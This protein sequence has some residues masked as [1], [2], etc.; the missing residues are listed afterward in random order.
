MR[1]REFLASGLA[2]SAA[3]LAGRAEAQAAP[4]SSSGEA[5]AGGSRQWLELRKYQLTQG[6]QGRLLSSYLSG[7][8]IPALNKMGIGPVGAFTLTYGPDTPATYLLLPSSSLETLV[9]VQEKLA[10]DPAFTEAAK[11]FWSVPAVSAPFV[12]VESQLLRAMAG[13]PAVTPPKEKPKNRCFQLRT[14]ESATDLDHARKVEMFHQGEFGFFQ[15]A[16]ADTIFFAD[17]L[18]GPRMPSLTYMLGFGSPEEIDPKWAVFN[19]IPAWKKLNQN[20]RY[21]FEPTVS[22]VS[23]LILKPAA[24]SQ[25]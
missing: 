14:Y 1:R 20:P 10:E 5:P 7:A 8:L 13:Y 9:M 4:A 23:N 19:N 24:Y 18:I 11:A 15:Q 12:R 3:A 21:T 2:A 22:N 17:T 25:I 16:G 6:P